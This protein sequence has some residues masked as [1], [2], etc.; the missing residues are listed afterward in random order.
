MDRNLTQ[1]DVEELGFEYRLFS[2]FEIDLTHSEKQD[3]CEHER[4]LPVVHP[5]G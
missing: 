5:E 2:G 1:A 4:F 3:T